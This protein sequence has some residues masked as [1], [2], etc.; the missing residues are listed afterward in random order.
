MTTIE[1]AT[2]GRIVM[3]APPERNVF[4]YIARGTVNVAGKP[5]DAY[6]LVEMNG[7]GDEVEIEA[8]SESIVIFGHAMPYREP[9]VSYGPF[10]MNT[11]GEIRQAMLDY[12]A[13]K[14]R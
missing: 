3:P 6:H 7:D 10:V 14:F 9:V 5:V 2:G 11:Q 13:G 8:V 12:Q 4:L 1:L